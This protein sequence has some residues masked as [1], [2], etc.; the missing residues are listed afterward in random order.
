MTATKP[1]IE[2]V[3]NP[4]ELNVAD[5]RHRVQGSI[6][7]PGEPGYDTGRRVWNGMIDKH[8]AVI[9]RCATPGDVAEAIG[10]A[11]TATFRSPCARAGITWPEVP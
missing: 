4:N 7:T 1:D 6:L 8:P 9:A 2:Q 3:Q 10:F 5:L 11:R